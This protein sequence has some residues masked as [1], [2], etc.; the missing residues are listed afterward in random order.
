MERPT[1]MTMN[2]MWVFLQTNAMA[3]EQDVYNLKRECE[4]KDATIKE[5]T[6]FLQSCDAAG[7]KASSL[8]NLPLLSFLLKFL[9]MIIKIFHDTRGLQNLKTLYAG[10]M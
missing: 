3:I 7:S 1:F 2:L 6:G 10:R 8:L 5:L 4:E 9:L